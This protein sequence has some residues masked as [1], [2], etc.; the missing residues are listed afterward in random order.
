MFQKGLEVNK[1]QLDIWIAYLEYLKKNKSEEFEG[2][3][4]KS[5][6]VMASHW[7]ADKF[8]KYWIRKE[9]I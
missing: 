9:E 3:W 6:E 8:W 5:R 7:E 4:E 1:A 2:K